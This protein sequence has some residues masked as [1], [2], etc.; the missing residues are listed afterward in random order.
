MV[1]DVKGAGASTSAGGS[2]KGHGRSART[3]GSTRERMLLA[4]DQVFADRGYSGATVD[5]VISAAHTSRASFYRYF[6]SMEDLF[7][8]LSRTCFLEMRAI[9]REFGSLGEA[10]TR[11]ERLEEIISAYAELHRRHGGV[12]RAWT[13]RS[14][15]PDSPEKAGAARVF[16]ALLDE[17]ARAI[18]SAQAP[19]GVAPEVEAALLFV[20]IERSAYYVS[21]RHSVVGRDRLAPT[22][23]TMVHRTWFGG[24]TSPVRAAD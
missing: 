14:T 3:L 13:E 2:A 23:S 8:E 18:S 1:A 16:G 11:R 22:L 5:E 17:M 7:A 9:V 10:S 15:P 4:G 12:I 24:Q 20:L 19:S 21:N 6:R